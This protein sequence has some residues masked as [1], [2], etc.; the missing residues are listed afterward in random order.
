MQPTQM[1]TMTTETNVMTRMT[2]MAMA[3]IA[4]MMEMLALKVRTITNMDKEGH[5]SERIGGYDANNR[6]T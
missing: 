6:K 5:D 4:D 2:C 1:L 3:S